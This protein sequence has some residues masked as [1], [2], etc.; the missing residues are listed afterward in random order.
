MKRI[1]VWIILLFGGAGLGV[2][3]DNFLF[4]EIRTSLIFHI[5][6]FVIGLLILLLVI[7]ISKNTGR[8][9]A[10]YGRKG[11]IPK[12][13]TNVLVA[14]GVYKYMRHPMHLGLLLF[15]LSI[16]FLIGSPSFIF[17]IAPVEIILMFLM[18]KLIEEPEAIKKF[19][20][21]YIEYKNHLPWFCFKIPCLKEL[22]KKV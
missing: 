12:M 4:K 14:Q 22:M 19:G 9:L 21:E 10:K 2:F 8:T 7:R 20:S 11:N 3:L 6:S 16:A 13:D 15:P 1:L 17:I 5:I 18:I